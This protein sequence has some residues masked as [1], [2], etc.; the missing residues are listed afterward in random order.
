MENVAKDYSKSTWF[1]EEESVSAQRGQT[2]TTP[3]QARQNKNL[4]KSLARIHCSSLG[5]V[6]SLVSINPIAAVI[7]IA[8]AS[9]EY[10]VF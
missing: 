9:T 10:S 4:P 7:D 1:D 5:A 8:P 3:A 6:I 2:T